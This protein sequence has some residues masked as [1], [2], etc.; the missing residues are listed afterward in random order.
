MFDAVPTME[1]T[2]VTLRPLQQSDA[3]PLFEVT[4]QDTFRLFLSWPTEWTLPAF[5][6]WVAEKLFGPRQRPM[7]VIDRASGKVIGSTSFMDIDPANRAV[8]VGA[9]WYSPAFR[10]TAI[11]PES[12]LLMLAH[13]FERENCVRVTL[14]TD[15]RNEHSQRAIAKLGASYEGILRQHRIQQNGFARDTVYFSVLAE[16]WARIK[17]GLQERLA[18]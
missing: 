18:S 4:S 7:A 17:R 14:K 9:T 8:E 13:A 16:E 5:E 11:N 12:K 15:K 3:K 1:G 10:G 2:H 6:K